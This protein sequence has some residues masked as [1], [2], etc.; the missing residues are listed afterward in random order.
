M[1]QQRSTYP[2]DYSKGHTEEDRHPDSTVERVKDAAAEV[3]DYA[4]RFAEQARECGEKAQKAARSFK[5]CV[6][7]SMKEQP[8]AALTVAS[9]IGFVLG[10]LWKK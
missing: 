8:M 4:G 2:L 10:A 7:R 3:Q 5:P 1:A 6:E 9:V